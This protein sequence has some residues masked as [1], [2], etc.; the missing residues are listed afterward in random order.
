MSATNM[1]RSNS[2]FL[3]ATVHEFMQIWALNGDA[4]LNLTTSG[5]T[6]NLD[7]KCSLGQPGAPHSPPPS[8]PSSPPPPA[9]RRPCHRGPAEREKNRLRAA[10]HQAAWAK[11]AAPVSPVE[12]S[13]AASLTV[14]DSSESPTAPV[15]PEKTAAVSGTEEGE[16]GCSPDFKCEQCDYTNNTV[17]GLGQ[18][19]RM[20]HR[21]SQVDGNIDSDEESIEETYPVHII[22]VPF[23]CPLCKE[24]DR[25][26][27]GTCIGECEGCDQARTQ[28]EYDNIFHIMNQHDPKE[29][30]NYFGR[31]YVTEHQHTISRNIEIFQDVM[32]S[33]KWDKI[34]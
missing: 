31:D 17:N 21:V 26:C 8:A 29:V 22:D 1:S 30:L 14:N 32:H 34:L 18:H 20:K 16:S 10:R 9:P 5:G 33:S 25:F 28:T 23:P 13:V 4:I 3:G 15:A 6:V 27:T 12:S 7:F 24:G 19:V 2:Q 11:T